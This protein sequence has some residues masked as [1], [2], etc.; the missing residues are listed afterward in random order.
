M[1]KQKGPNSVQNRHIYTRASYLYQA[2]Q[3]LSSQQTQASTSD[4]SSNAGQ[5]QNAPQNLSRQMLTDMRIVTQK[6][7]IRQSPDLK[8]TVCKFCDTL[9][10]EGQTSSSI[11]ENTSKGGRKPWADVLAIRC[12]TCGHVK[13]FPICAKRQQRRPLRKQENRD[14]PKSEEMAGDAVT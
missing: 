14:E 12:C 3:Y 2:A 6:I 7:L 4:T 8:R 11:V 13:R 10:I 1:A 9:Q 5:S